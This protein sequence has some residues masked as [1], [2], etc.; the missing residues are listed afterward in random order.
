MLYTDI[1]VI[2]PD[3]SEWGLLGEKKHSC[4]K[5]DL[6]FWR[7]EVVASNLLLYTALWGQFHSLERLCRMRYF[8]FRHLG[9]ARRLINASGIR[10][11]VRGEL[12][13]VQFSQNSLQHPMHWWLLDCEGIECYLLAGIS[14]QLCVQLHTWKLNIQ[15]W[16]LIFK[17][18]FEGDERMC[19]IDNKS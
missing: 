10:S 14:L 1:L 3:R 4:E 11:A 17:I 18:S 2:T 16:N 7:D 5:E 19:S 12:G 15:A 9:F 8:L 13:K 6:M